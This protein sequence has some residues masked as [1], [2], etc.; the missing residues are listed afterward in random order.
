MC[1]IEKTYDDAESCGIDDGVKQGQFGTRK[2]A[3]D[4]KESIPLNMK[5]GFKIYNFIRKQSIRKIFQNFLKTYKN[6]DRT[7]LIFITSKI[8]MG[9]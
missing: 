8:G 1:G 6:I 7:R 9:R 3:A 5:Y 2:I 4:G